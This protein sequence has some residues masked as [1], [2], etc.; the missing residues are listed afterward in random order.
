L[1]DLIISRTTT[2]PDYFDTVLTLTTT[3]L[4][5]VT[6]TITVLA[7]DGAGGKATNSF[8]ATALGDT[9]NDQPFLFPVTGVTNLVASMNGRLTNYF[10]ALDLEN[11][12]YFW[13][14]QFK[15]QAT[16]NNVTNSSYDILPDGNLTVFIVPNSNFVGT[17]SLYAIVS[18]SSIWNIFP[19]SFPYDLQQYTF[20][21][22]DTAISAV[23]TNFSAPP[24][25]TFTNQLLATFTN[26]VR[27][28]AASNFTAL[29][30]WGDNS[31]N[32]AVITTNAS[33]EKEVRGS[34]AYVNPGTYPVYVTIRSA[35][36]AAATVAATTIVPPNLTLT[37]SG[38]THTLIWPGWAMDFMLQSLTNVAS[39]NWLNSAD[40][41][42]LI[43]HDLVVTNAGAGSRQFFRLKLKE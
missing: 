1:A 19:G 12:A 24:L 37:R 32:S 6:G 29:I 5:G 14:P 20:V 28:S 35:I 36:G 16:F 11:D 4:A 26:G 41:P 23:P 38:A 21:F 33:G 27:N 2:V 30:N 22:G 13:F 8:V 18:S 43:G 34:H 39:A 9:G 40:T 10:T 25:V 3:N 17:V 31:T 15:D 7:D 42:A